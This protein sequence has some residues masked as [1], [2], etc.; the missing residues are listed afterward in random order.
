MRKH[1]LKNAFYTVRP[2]T[3]VELEEVKENRQIKLP[4][5][6]IAEVPTWV[7]VGDEMCLVTG[8]DGES[9]ID[10]KE[11]VELNLDPYG[12]PSTTSLRDHFAGLA[13]Q[14]YIASDFANASTTTHLI[15]WTSDFAYRMADAMLKDREEGKDGI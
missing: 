11:S 5:G 14:A 10:T 1:V 9:I 2:L 6:K 8:S 7:S 12:E 15:D 13:M 4:D 3:D